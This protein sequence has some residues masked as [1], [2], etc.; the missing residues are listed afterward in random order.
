MV[1]P[2][3]GAGQTRRDSLHVVSR[4]ARLVPWLLPLALLLGPHPAAAHNLGHKRTPV[5][6][7]GE[8][9]M[10]VIDRASNG[11]IHELHYDIPFEDTQLSSDEPPDSRRHQFFAFCR[12][13]HFEYRNPNWITEAELAIGDALGLGQA[14]F[15]DLEFDV[16]ELAPRWQDCFMRINAD[17]ERRPIS[18]E[19][20]AEPVLW[21]TSQLAAGSYV[22]EAYTWEPWFNLWTEH[23]GVFRIIDDPDPAANPPA[24]ALDYAEQVVTVGDD[25]V[26]SG[27]IAAMPGSTMS[28]SWVVGGSGLEP[29]WTPFVEKQP[30]EGES[31][32]LTLTGPETALG[33]YL[34]IRL[35]VE[36]PQG[37]TWTAYGTKYIGVVAQPPMASDE[38]GSTDGGELE[39]EHAPGCGCA[40]APRSSWVDAVPVLGVL[41]WLRRR[42][43]R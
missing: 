4:A 42:R 29:E 37:R 14:M 8:P 30:V 32:E 18:F 5:L 34:L 15:V 6:W 28:L 36:D 39:P 17:D 9:C 7:D 24:A 20:A 21:D 35:D 13:H 26:I 23:P 2:R 31:F 27:C 3:A 33:R 43:A 22:V 41:V 40:S 12:D 38:S 25:A 10:T 16:L 1:E 19:A 11:P